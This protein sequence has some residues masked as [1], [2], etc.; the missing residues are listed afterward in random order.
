MYSTMHKFPLILT[1]AILL[2]SFTVNA[3]GIDAESITLK[4]FIQIALQPVGQT[5]YVWGGGWNEADTGAGEEAL[6]IGVS[7]NW[8]VFFEGQ[9]RYYDY[10]Q[11]NYMIHSGLDCS[12]FLGWV[13]FNLI[14]NEKGYVMKSGDLTNA[15]VSLNWGEKYAKNKIKKH[16]PGDIMGKDGHVWISLGTCNDGSVLIL[17]SSPPGVS[18]Y[19]TQNGKRKSEAILLAELYMSRFFP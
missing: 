16:I 19:G 6:T 1:L 14:P 11:F 7:P 5:M 9:S 17:Q 18:L 4:Q 8:K 12:G 10:T 2:I 13:L 3:F 15:L